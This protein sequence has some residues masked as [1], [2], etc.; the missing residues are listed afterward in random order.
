MKYRVHNHYS[1]LMELPVG[2]KYKSQTQRENE[3]LQGQF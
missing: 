1:E 2:M 3:M